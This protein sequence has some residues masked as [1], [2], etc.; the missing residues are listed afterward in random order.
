[1]TEQDVKTKQEISAEFVKGVVYLNQE[2]K[3]LQGSKKDLKNDYIDRNLLTKEEV[4]R[5]Y[6]EDEGDPLIKGQRK[7][8]HQEMAMGD[9]AQQVAASDVVVTNPTHLAVAIKYDQTEMVAPQIMAKGQRL[10]AQMIREVADEHNIPI[11]RN[12]PLA[13]ALTE[14]EV[15]DE[16]AF[17]LWLGEEDRQAAL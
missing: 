7:Q 2:I 1:M 8:L 4:K 16:V 10:F 9:V 13:W 11:M 6:K 12:V 15:G 14:L 5:E 3:L 17:L